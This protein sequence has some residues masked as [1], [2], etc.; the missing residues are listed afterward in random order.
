MKKLLLSIALFSLA[1][2][3]DG[4][5]YV[6]TSLGS[7]ANACTASGASACATLSGAVGKL[8]KPIT[9]STTIHV[10]GTAADTTNVANLSGHSTTNSNWI[11]IQMDTRNPTGIYSASYYRIQSSAG[12]QTLITVGDNY[13]K[14]IGLQIS[15]QDAGTGVLINTTGTTDIQVAD[16]IIRNHY[17]SGSG[18]FGIADPHTGTTIRAWNNIIYWDGTAGGA[19]YGIRFLNTSG[20]TNYAY[21]NTIVGFAEGIHKYGTTTVIN[22][23]FSGN[24]ADIGNGPATDTYNATNNTS[25][26]GL[27][28]VG[29]GGTGNRFSQ[30][31]TFAGAAPDYLL[32]ASDAG[33]KG[34]G[35]TNPGSGLFSD[36]ILATARTAPW[37]IGAHQVSTSASARRRANVIQ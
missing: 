26:A 4:P 29:G 17:V 37:D 13:V 7:D 34:Y 3:A 36:D 25:A 5:Y 31:F 16:C 12:G 10:A 30:T 6:N 19:Q 18:G 8:A 24:T 23:L 9:S 33:A 2:W 22:N 20:S 1:V 27:R 14:I 15:F 32:S 35:M 28:T 11:I 21:N